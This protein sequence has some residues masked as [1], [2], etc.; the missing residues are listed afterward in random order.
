M[1]NFLLAL[2]LLWGA[3][4]MYAAQIIE[5]VAGGGSGGDGVP[6][7]EAKLV[8]PFGVEFNSK[9]DMYIAEMYGHRI[10]M[11][12]AKGVFHVIAGDGTKGDSG[13]G[14]PAKNAKVNGPH[15]LCITPNDDIYIADTFNNKVRKIDAKTGIITTVCGTGKKGY[16]GDGGPAT[17]A[18]MNEVIN[19]AFDPKFEKLYIDEI[20]NKRVRA[21]D[22]KTGVISLV[23]GNGV[24]GVPP[25]GANAKEAPLNDPR[26]LAI[27]KAGNIYILE[28]GGHQLR[29][30]DPSGKLKAIA[31]TG[32]PGF[33]GDDGP[34]LQAQL[35]G[36]KFLFMD[37]DENVLIADSDNHAIRKVLV[38]EGKMIRLAGTGK[39]APGEVGGDP[40]K[41]DL[42]K[43]HGV[44]VHPDGTLYI[45]DS[46]N[47][48]VLKIK[49]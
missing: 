42:N 40:L 21:Y 35:K 4:P 2:T 39:M 9:G 18:D 30:M 37:Q 48:R 8:G 6:A 49:R 19:I 20:G 22:M 3:L 41:C 17:A 47:N 11:V 45:S 31:G 5:L 29:I 26:A 1:R 7:K 12:D 13:D 24:R 15:N 27:D 28:R 16:S 23:A 36:P 38:K 43:P 46:D 44:Y 33:G 10:S 34:A 32:K 25:D 14:G